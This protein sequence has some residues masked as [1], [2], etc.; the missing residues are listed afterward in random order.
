MER[1]SELEKL[2]RAVIKYFGLQDKAINEGIELAMSGDGAEIT[3]SKEVVGQTVLE[4]KIIDPAATDPITGE[5]CF[6]CLPDSDVA[7]EAEE[8]CRYQSTNN[9]FVATIALAK[10]S[11]SLP[12]QHFHN[13][14][15][16]A[17]EL[18]K[19]GLPSKGS[20]PT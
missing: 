11:K 5:L 1:H 19:N 14:F 20:K 8:F 4:F 7:D 17:E 15:A 6:V 9:C 16:F 13:F 3:T 18:A 12:S 2:L 10:E